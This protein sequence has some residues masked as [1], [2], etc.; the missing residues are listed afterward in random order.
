[1]WY[2]PLQLHFWA[3]FYLLIFWTFFH[4]FPKSIPYCT[5]FSE[6]SLLSLLTETIINNCREI[7][8]FFF[9]KPTYICFWEYFR[10]FWEKVEHVLIACVRDIVL[11]KKQKKYLRRWIFRSFL[12]TMFQFLSIQNLFSPIILIFDRC[13][14]LH[15]N[16]SRYPLVSSVDRRR[17]LSARL[18]PVHDT[19]KVRCSKNI[20]ATVKNCAIMAVNWQW[21]FSEWNCFKN[22]HLVF[23]KYHF[24]EKTYF[25]QKT[26][27]CWSNTLKRRVER[28]EILKCFVYRDNYQKYTPLVSSETLRSVFR[29]FVRF[30]NPQSVD[31][32]CTSLM[33]NPG[34]QCVRFSPAL[35]S[36]NF[37]SLS[38]LLLLSIFT[39]F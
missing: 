27:K 28:F 24:N 21:K 31:S 5:F 8:R 25:R 15:E 35:C 14:R 18:I 16:L 26:T 39:F 2:I 34:Y 13:F 36:R 9:R 33:M 30:F 37:F 32:S 38:R 22:Y 10:R 7:F 1:M 20:R 29:I 17:P 19:L 6:G 12:Q 23:G 4:L 11:A 3:V